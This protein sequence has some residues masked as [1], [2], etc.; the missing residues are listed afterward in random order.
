MIHFR[1]FGIPVRIE[2]FFWVV[3]AIL[4]GALHADDSDKMFK[5][6]IFVFAGFISILTHECGHALTA[7]SFGAQT[8]IVLEAFGGYA[9]YGGVFI[10]RFKSLVITLAGPISQIALAV[11]LI[12]VKPWV[13]IDKT[14]LV[15]LHEKLIFISF[16]WALINLIPALPLDGGQIVHAILG[17]KHIRWTLWITILSSIGLGTLF[18]IS[19]YQSP[20]FAL[21]LFS[22]A[23]RAIQALRNKNFTQ[24]L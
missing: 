8:Y 9:A 4:G 12:F 1:I 10:N 24:V 19:D 11:I 18:L 21:F 15:D 5:T 23:W 16:F 14:Y 3:L 7:K 2:P 17:I 13:P 20:F 22:F 6:A